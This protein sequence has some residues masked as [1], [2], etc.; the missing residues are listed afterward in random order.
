MT[1]SQIRTRFSELRKRIKTNETTLRLTPTQALVL[2]NTLETVS[3]T[4]L[5]D[6]NESALIL[7]DN[8]LVLLAPYG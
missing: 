3:S 6:A 4:W 8:A 5:D 7:V 2:L 1:T